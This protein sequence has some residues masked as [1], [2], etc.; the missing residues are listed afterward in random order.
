MSSHSLSS[1]RIPYHSH[2]FMKRLLR[3]QQD[4]NGEKELIMNCCG[5]EENADDMY[6]T[7][8][9]G[10]N[11]TIIDFY[12]FSD[13]KKQYP[14]TEE[15]HALCNK[16]KNILKEYHES[17]GYESD[18]SDAQECYIEYYEDDENDEYS[19]RVSQEC[20]NEY[21]EMN[22]SEMNE[23]E[24]NENDERKF[25]PISM[26]SIKGNFF[27]QKVYQKALE[28]CKECG[29]DVTKVRLNG[30][31]NNFEILQYLPDLKE[32][33]VSYHDFLSN[34]FTFLEK[35]NNVKKIEFEIV[36]DSCE[37]SSYIIKN[38]SI[39]SQLES[40]EFL[41]FQNICEE[42]F[43]ILENS[44]PNLENLWMS[45]SNI[46]D[47]NVEVIL[48]NYK[49]LKNLTFYYCKKLTKKFIG[50]MKLEYPHVNTNCYW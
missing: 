49:N 5:G 40:L 42:S 37:E 18:E 35:C 15:E 10:D 17:E 21:Y 13:M 36:N 28:I 12:L 43:Q 29:K 19:K 46:S 2:E 11:L 25:F 27:D 23:S 8:F 30:I 20:Y 7:I 44:F 45:K 47:K 1:Q 33:L 41:N 9:W 34:D 26:R 48:A 14:M 22:E 3:F 32:I 16:T 50:Q 31:V 4:E 38:I 39:L 24:M 6:D